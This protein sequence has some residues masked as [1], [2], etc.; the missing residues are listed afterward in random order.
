MI[1]QILTP[2]HLCIGKNAHKLEPKEKKSVA[3]DGYVPEQLFC[4][5]AEQAELPDSSTIRSWFCGKTSVWMV[6]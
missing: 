2:D 6:R 1:M 3:A 5:P 4:H